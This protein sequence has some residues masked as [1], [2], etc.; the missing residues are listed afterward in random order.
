VSSRAQ[1]RRRHKQFRRKKIEAEIR[2]Y[3]ARRRRRLA[4]QLGVVLGVVGAVSALVVNARTPEE[5]SE[6]A[7][8]C[9]TK[10]PERPETQTNFPQPPTLA[11]DQAKTYS[12]EMETSCGTLTITLADDTSPQTVNSFVFLAK[13]KFFDGLTFHRI[14]P[15]AVQG[16]DPTG[17]GPGDP[18][19]RVVEAPPPE[20]TYA[21]GV[22]A[23][24]KGGDDPPG[25]SGSQFFI[26][27]NA[28]EA[29]RAML[30]GSPESPALYA[31][32]G[33][34][35]KG[36]DALDKLAAVDTYT[37]QTSQEKSTPRRPV[38]IVKVRI[39][40]S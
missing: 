24:A 22:V 27:S 35:T 20:F 30:N 39:T 13:Q 11:I 31:V 21:K 36:M 23:M 1:K 6:D 4:I 19:Y 2:A 40:E 14:T 34:V 38:Y 37:P 32:L 17:Q 7:Q 15:F 5:P 3:K 33:T 10:R 29:A 18:G 25:S 9:S 26:V 12:A 28:E 8:A 16:G